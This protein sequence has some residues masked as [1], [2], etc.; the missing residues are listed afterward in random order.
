MPVIKRLTEV[1]KNEELAKLLA[2]TNIRG[3]C[4]LHSAF[5]KLAAG[6]VGVMTMVTDVVKHLVALH[7]QHGISV[8]IQDSE[9]ATPLYLAAKYHVAAAV[10]I[11]I[12]AGADVNL[13]TTWG[14]TALTAAASGTSPSIIKELLA[15]GADPQAT[16]ERSKETALHLVVLSGLTEEQ[17]MDVCEH[18]MNAGADVNA[19][20]MDEKSPIVRAAENHRQKLVCAL[21]NCSLTFSTACGSIYV[22]DIRIDYNAT[23]CYCCSFICFCVGE[24][25]WTGCQRL[26]RRHS[27]HY[28]AAKIRSYGLTK[29]GSSSSLWSHVPRP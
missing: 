21:L 6:E 7:K 14:Y 10:N 19:L 24:A 28:T 29:C 17:C 26:E 23:R 1:L 16:V 27:M 20:D 3:N 12:G 22:C 4:A 25:P 11:L 8:D 13:T 2:R 18:L 5:D 9:G 15:A